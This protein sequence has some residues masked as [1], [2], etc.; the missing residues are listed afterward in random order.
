MLSLPDLP[1]ELLL[2][3]VKY[4]PEQ[5]S[6]LDASV[7][8]THSDQFDGNDTLR[9]LSQ[10]CRTL[11]D[12]FLP[13]LWAHVHAYFT[14]RN[15]PKRKIKTRAKMLEHRMRGIQRTS[16]VIPYIHSLSITLEECNHDNWQPLSQFIR[17]LDLLPNLQSLTILRIP[18]EMIAV[19]QTSFREKL[20]PSITAL[21]L[22]DE[23]AGILHCFPNV[24]EL[25]RGSDGYTDKL[26]NASKDIYKHVRTVN[27]VSANVVKGNPT[28]ATSINMETYRI[29]Y[30]TSPRGHGQPVRLANTLSKRR[31]RTHTSFG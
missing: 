2:E 21:A 5:L 29:G 30:V 1:T 19:C 18:T 7:H 6:S 10:T 22:P 13:V 23:L 4:Y 27:N 26:F 9:A 28:R 25:T 31:L 8:G 20:Y 17:V 12:V 24:Q 15:L 16:H 3:I 14:V 11:R